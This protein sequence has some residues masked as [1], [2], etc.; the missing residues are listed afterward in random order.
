MAYV[1]KAGS[2]KSLIHSAESLVWSSESCLSRSRGSLSLHRCRSRA[3]KIAGVEHPKGGFTSS[4]GVSSGSGGLTF[5]TISP[6]YSYIA[7]GWLQAPYDSC[8]WEASAHVEAFHE[9]KTWRNIVLMQQEWNLLNVC[10]LDLSMV[11][12]WRMSDAHAYLSLR[13]MR[14]HLHSFVLHCCQRRDYDKYT[15]SMMTSVQ[16]WLTA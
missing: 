7:S 14:M 11:H 12:R 13:S 15:A 4:M 1:W 2:S 16:R 5:S 9:I 3:L 6:L 10:A 8:S